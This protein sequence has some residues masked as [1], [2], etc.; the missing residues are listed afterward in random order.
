M[1]F[2]RFEIERPLPDVEEFEGMEQDQKDRLKELDLKVSQYTAM[3]TTFKKKYFKT[4]HF[5][6]SHNESKK[7]GTVTSTDTL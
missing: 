4:I 5:P 2:E 6:G 7:R 1:I 3:L